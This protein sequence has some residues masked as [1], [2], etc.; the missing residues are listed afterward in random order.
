MEYLHARRVLKRKLTSKSVFVE[1]D[2]KVMIGDFSLATLTTMPLA[3]DSPLP[4]PAPHRRRSNRSVGSFAMASPYS[5]P[6][7][8]PTHSKTLSTPADTL[9]TSSLQLAKIGPLRSLAPEILAS[10]YVQKRD[11]ARCSVCEAWRLI[12]YNA[13][14]H[15]SPEAFTYASDVYA[16]GVVVYELLAMA[17][18][19]PGLLPEQLIYTIVHDHQLPNVSA[20]RDDCPPVLLDLIMDSLG[21]PRVFSWGEYR[22]IHNAPLLPHSIPTRRAANL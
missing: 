17:N 3:T 18:P 7:M 9:P 2:G 22:A 11:A 1:T 13:T 14:L 5:S 4:S 20:C 16:F 21:M 6:V 8:S 19:W 12:R 15:R 10:G